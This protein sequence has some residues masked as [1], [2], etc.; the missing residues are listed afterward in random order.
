M[1]FIASFL[2]VS[3]FVVFVL[4]I[5]FYFTREYV[6]YSGVQNFKKSVLVL[7]RTGRS[8]TICSEKGTD[9][10]GV[11]DGSA[12]SVAQIRFTSTTEYILEVLCAGYTF[13]PITLEK[14]Q[15]DQFV[16]K[17]SG[18][19]GIV[20]GTERSGVELTAFQ[21]VEDE[22]NSAFKTNWRFIHKS[23]AVVFEN[24]DFVVLQPG[25]DL[26]VS[27]VSSCEGFG[28]QCCDVDAQ[29]GV[30]EALQ[31]VTSCEQSCYSSC[32]RRPLVLSLNSNPFF[33][34]A[35][36]IVSVSA[37]ESVDFAYVIDAGSVKSLQVVTDFGDGT[38]EDTTETTATV[39]HVYSC[40]TDVCEYVV[41]VRAADAWGI[42]ST[43]TAISQLKVQVGAPSLE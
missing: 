16:T 11:G 32:V 36:R 34:V 39:S 37:G 18:T 5:G 7:E 28:Y 38:T 29:Q 20:V 1:R 26:G 33:D 30:G 3:L 4:V 40:P 12:G 41:S 17:S 27:P 19:A 43:M 42:Q 24:N 2:T 14:K 10:L 9:L 31:G 15:L 8:S 13:D 6:L 21:S 35:T 23:N 25:E 22:I